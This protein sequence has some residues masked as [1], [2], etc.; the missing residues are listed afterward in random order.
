MSTQTALQGL[1][2]AILAEPGEDSLRLIYT[3]LL[4]E[5]G[6]PDRAEL[7]RLQIALARH[8]AATRER[9]ASR[10]IPAGYI[11]FSKRQQLM[12][13]ERELLPPLPDW[14]AERTFTRGFISDVAC[15]TAAWLEHG[16]AL[17]REHPV[18]VVRLLDRAAHRFDRTPANPGWHWI[19][20][21][22][23]LLTPDDQNV[24]PEWLWEVYEAT[25]SPR[26]WFT[27]EAANA[28]LS[29]A[30]LCWARQ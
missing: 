3:D 8:T 2:D 25:T 22:H 13:R 28:A 1:L 21:R 24:L 29:A 18:E 15:S 26:M 4:E 10:L 9:L 17:V 7:I 11:L 12:K 27:E 6:E 20:P 5:N 19:P 16:K 14:M 30:C 23:P